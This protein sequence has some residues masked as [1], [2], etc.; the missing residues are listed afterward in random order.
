M[1][2]SKASNGALGAARPLARLSAGELLAGYK[3]RRF[4]PHDVIEDV[5]CALESAHAACRVM[6]TPM[7]EQARAQADLA[8]A[9]WADG[10]PAEPLCAVP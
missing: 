8:S 5:I 1:E 7:F 9:K 6:V 10:E 4:T 2:G 3:V